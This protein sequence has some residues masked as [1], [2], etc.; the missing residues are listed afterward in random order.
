MI[1]TDDLSLLVTEQIV[2][3]IHI[4]IVGPVWT[5]TRINKIGLRL[6]SDFWIYKTGKT[7]GPQKVN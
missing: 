4:R 6:D 7:L 1:P 5:L 3:Q 2:L